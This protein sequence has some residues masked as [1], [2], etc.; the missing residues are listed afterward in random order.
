MWVKERERERERDSWYGCVKESVVRRK[1]NREERER[2]CVC[3]GER[4]RD[5]KLT[6]WELCLCPGADVINKFNVA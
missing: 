4:Y 6:A 1:M 5:Y 3:V 2:K